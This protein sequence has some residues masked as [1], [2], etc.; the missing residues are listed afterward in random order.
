MFSLN[1]VIST[2]SRHRF[3]RPTPCFSMSSSLQLLRNEETSPLKQ[4]PLVFKYIQYCI[5]PTVV[6]SVSVWL[7]LTVFFCVCVWVCSFLW[8]SEQ[9]L[10]SHFCYFSLSLAWS[11]EKTAFS[12]DVL[13]L[14]CFTVVLRHSLKKKNIRFRPYDNRYIDWKHCTLVL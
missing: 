2:Q 3:S 10:Y 5:I 11:G 8:G 7:T 1:N 13:F 6:L 14:L 4:F 12:W 9:R